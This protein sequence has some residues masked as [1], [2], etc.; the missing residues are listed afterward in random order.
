MWEVETHTVPQTS[1]EPESLKAREVGTSKK[2]SEGES[3]PKPEVLKP[4]LEVSKPKLKLKPKSEDKGLGE[5]K[6]GDYFRTMG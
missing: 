2:R 6:S 3:K 4:K 1:M 5:G